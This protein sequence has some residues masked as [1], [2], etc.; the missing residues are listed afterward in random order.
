MIAVSIFVITVRKKLCTEI[1]DKN[2]RIRYLEYPFTD[3][4]LS[5]SFNKV[6]DK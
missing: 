2:R 4:A 3:D 6:T 1:E 5:I